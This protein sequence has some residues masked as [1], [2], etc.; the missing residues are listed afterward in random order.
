MN[1]VCPSCGTPFA[2]E[3]GVLVSTSGK[4]WFVA[5]VPDLR[6]DPEGVDHFH[7]RCWV[8]DHGIGD[9]LKLVQVE[10]EKWR[11]SRLAWLDQIRK[12][13]ARLRALG[14]TPDSN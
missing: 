1:T 7:V 10:D 14:E 9:F 4:P 12:L 3:S 8:K 2:D 5:Y 13:E 6:I 11:M